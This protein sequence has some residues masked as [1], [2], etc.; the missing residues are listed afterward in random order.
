MKTKKPINRFFSKKISR[1]EAIKK[2]GIT[3]LTSASLMFLQTQAKAQNS[4]SYNNPG[5]KGDPPG[6]RG[7]DK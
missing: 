5:K 7:R 3:A 6:Q 4:K 2:A 1:K